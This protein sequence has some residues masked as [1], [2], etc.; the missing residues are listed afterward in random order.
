[1]RLDRLLANSGYGSRTTVKDLIRAK[2]VVVDGKTVTDSAFNVDETNMP[3]IAVSGTKIKAVRYLHYMLNKPEGC[4]TALDDPRHATVAQFFPSNL[5]TAGVFPVGRLDIDT[6]GLLLF[7]N[8]G[9]LCHRLTGPVWHVD[10][11]YYFELTDKY[12]GDDDVARLAEGIVL[13]G[14]KQCRPAQLAILTPHSGL[15][16]IRE[17][18]YHQVKRMMKA[19]GG[20]V[21]VL[22]RRSMGPV[23]LPDDLK[24]GEIRP[25]SDDEICALY[26][27]AGMEFPE[28]R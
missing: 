23:R 12:L 8:D 18:K 9:T 6:T 24:Q 5:L 19:L 27:A 2:K 16:T 25:L 1:M 11:V 17:G 15:L 20:T 7:T 28:Y 22:E 3:E 10:K 14:E 13:D 21:S 26:I 4:I